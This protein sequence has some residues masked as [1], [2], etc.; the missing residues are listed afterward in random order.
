MATRWVMD[1][2]VRSR[3]VIRRTLL[4]LGLLTA[5]GAA[6]TFAPPALASGRMIDLGS[7][8]TGCG[9]TAAAINDRG[10]IAGTSCTEPFRWTRAAGMQGLGSLSSLD[11]G[12]ATAINSLGQV[13]GWSLVSAGQVPHPFVWTPSGG[14]LDLTPGTV[15]G[16]S[17]GQ[18]IND[19]GEVAGTTL[20]YDSCES[21]VIF[22]PSQGTQQDVGFNDACVN[23]V[24]VGPGA[25]V[26]PLNFALSCCVSPSA[27]NNLGDV[28]GESQVST[29]PTVALDA[30][31]YTPSGGTQDLGTL[32]GDVESTGVAVNDRGQV[33]GNS[34]DASG[35]YHA[36]RWTR[37][38]GMQELVLPDGT[39]SDAVG[40]ND[41][42]EVAG[43]S[44]LAN[45]SVH[46][47]LWSPC[48]RIR[49]LGPGQA[50]AINELGQVA[51]A[52][53]NGGTYRWTPA[54]GRQY[55]G[56]GTPTAINDWGQITG[57]GTNGDAFLWTP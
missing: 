57:D 8:G 49:D 16:E 13:T 43:Y 48:G 46:A 41:L 42:G 47:F 39:S 25:S 54:R 14:M 37:S 28:T 5:V 32:P 33:A 15:E 26:F 44:Q 56:S 29:N 35:V 1:T 40:I 17:W 36:F 12:S 4:C 22:S 19:S 31:L 7:L 11:Q 20:G 50:V 45:G 51:I 2:T 6:G 24:G 38:G 30:Y 27:L 52:G 23:T 21:A 53:P 9:S 55:I 10:Q 18:A 34:V 3:R